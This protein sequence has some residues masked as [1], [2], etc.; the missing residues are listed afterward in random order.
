MIFSI[1]YALGM[2]CKIYFMVVKIY[3]NENQPPYGGWDYLKYS[4]FDTFLITSNSLALMYL[5]SI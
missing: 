5:S 4:A 2:E 1:S 3:F